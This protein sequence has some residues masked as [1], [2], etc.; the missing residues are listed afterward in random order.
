DL[1]SRDPHVKRLSKRL[2]RHKDEIF[3]FLNNPHEISP[4]NNDSLSRS[5]YYSDESLE[6]ANHA[7]FAKLA[8]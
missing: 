1:K 6:P 5:I 8:G 2:R 4:Y 7:L 3:T